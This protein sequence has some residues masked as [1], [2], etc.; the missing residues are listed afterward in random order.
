MTFKEALALFDN[1]KCKMAR[2]LQVTRQTIHNWG[3]DPDKEL[4]LTRKLQVQYVVQANV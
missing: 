1:N 4:P 3:T 2:E